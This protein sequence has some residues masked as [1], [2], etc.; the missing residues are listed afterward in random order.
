M[1]HHYDG[2]HA[3]H[4]TRGP[5]CTGKRQLWHSRRC[6]RLT[7]VWATQ[8][9]NSDE[10]AVYVFN[11]SQQPLDCTFLTKL[12]A[13]NATVGASFGNAL[14]TSGSV[15]FVGA[16]GMTV[17][18]VMCGKV[19]AFTCS[20]SSSLLTSLTS[21]DAANYDYFGGAI[22]A[23][24]PLVV[25]GAAGK[26]A[27]GNVSQGEAYVFGCS[28]SKCTQITS[29]LAND[30][31][32]QDSYGSA[33]AV[34]GVLVAIGAAFKSVGSNA[35]QGVI[36]MYTCSTAL[37]CSTATRLLA[38]DGAAND[39]LGYRLA[40]SGAL[41]FAVSMNKQVENSYQGA[42]YVFSCPTSSSCVQSNVLTTTPLG[43]LAAGAG[44]GG[45]TDVAASGQLVVLGGGDMA[46]PGGWYEQ[47]TAS[48][49][50]CSQS[51]LCSCM[52]GYGGTN[53]SVCT[54]GTINGVCTAC[55]P[56]CATCKLGYPSGCTS[57]NGTSPYL[58]GT[59]CVQ[60]CTLPTPFLQSGV[61]VGSC[62][63][64]FPMLVN[65]ICTQICQDPLY[66]IV[67]G[68]CVPSGTGTG[69]NTPTLTPTTKSMAPTRSSAMSGMLM[70]MVIAMATFTL[71]L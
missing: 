62:S 27:G 68:V 55:F 20:T 26:Y 41:L 28:G 42:V 64:S 4:D 52:P 3:D 14:A 71:L 36:Y 33:V 37:A 30:G 43:V 51:G 29:L 50:L 19:F 45:L 25:I 24:L 31:L 32:A 8:R 9:Q 47:G 21:S 39:Y 69:T 10:G 65:N 17:N 70:V 59:T 56:P 49:F 63:L 12:V 1:Q 13:P 16:S 7:C 22:A 15:L 38:S 44:G 54:A 23:S 48:T 58:Q 40:S 6:Q 5:G 11:C 34:S 18:N 60:A 57:C 2:V 53:C 35:Y 66:T 67:G 61:C 46:P